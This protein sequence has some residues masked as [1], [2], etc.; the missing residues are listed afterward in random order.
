MC[1]IRIIDTGECKKSVCQSFAPPHPT[2][3]PPILPHY[4]TPI[5][6]I[7]PPAPS[8]PNAVVVTASLPAEQKTNNQR[9]DAGGKAAPDNGSQQIVV[10]PPKTIARIPK[11]NIQTRKP[12]AHLPKIVAHT[13]KT[14][15]Q[16]K[17]P[18]TIQVQ[19]K[20]IQKPNAKEN[21]SDK[22]VV[23]KKGKQEKTAVAASASDGQHPTEE[24]SG[25]NKKT[26]EPSIKTTKKRS[27]PPEWV[28]AKKS[29]EDESETAPDK[30]QRTKINSPSPEVPHFRNVR[31]AIGESRRTLSTTSSSSTSSESSFIDPHPYHINRDVTRKHSKPLISSTKLG[32]PF[33]ESMEESD[34]IESEISSNIDAGDNLESIVPWEETEFLKNP[35]LATSQSHNEP[36]R[37]R[38]TSSAS[39]AAHHDF[40]TL[41]GQPATNVPYQLLPTQEWETMSDQESAT[42]RGGFNQTPMP[43]EDMSS[44]DWV[45]HQSSQGN[46]GFGAWL[47]FLAK[48]QARDS[49]RAAPSPKNFKDPI[50]VYKT[51]KKRFAK[52]EQEPLLAIQKGPRSHEGDHAH[53]DGPFPNEIEKMEEPDTR[54]ATRRLSYKSP[55][56]VDEAEE[57]VHYD[58]GLQIFWRDV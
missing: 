21:G 27:R 41:L 51:N 39:H 57:P 3:I 32:Q 4:P 13:P 37:D 19:P 23:P 36:T 52:T 17:T 18:E 40:M 31:F 42:D 11:I 8:L 9:K 49:P 44:W 15:A 45:R 28:E 35:G 5:P 24:S 34:S 29:D 14:I 12:V 6:P 50:L 58:P 2:P 53:T 16:V 20:S 33:P 55:S 48:H 7:L 26:K 38:Q 43:D 56:A 46:S 1:K 47:K 10:R 30:L 54:K 22:R 25:G